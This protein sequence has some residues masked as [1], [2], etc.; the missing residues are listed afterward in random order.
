MEL[1]FSITPA[2]TAARIAP[3]LARE[4]Q[5]HD[6]HMGKV[7]QLQNRLAARLVPGLVTA[8]A[9][10][11]PL[12]GGLAAIYFPQ[13]V[14]SAEKII[15]MLLFGLIYGLGWWLF[16]R[17]WLKRL[18]D[19][20]NLK[21]IPSGTPLRG[22]NQRLVEAKLRIPLKASEGAYRLLLDDQGFTLTHANGAT[23]GLAWEQV[24]H[25]AQSP[26]FYCLAS[27]DLHR[28]G[29]AY[30]IPKHSDLMDP[31]EYQQGIALLLEKCPVALE[32]T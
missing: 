24:A 29:K 11:L 32:P 4:M 25:L 21:P 26:D 15:A 5:Q 30:N 16:S 2:H 13:R 17:R 18:Q 8:L 27:A 6:Q 3:Q 7:T 31:D 28:Q 1:Q 10:A 14:F 12:A 9:F 19:N 23:G 20:I 22:L